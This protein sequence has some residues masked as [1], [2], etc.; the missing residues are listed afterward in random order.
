MLEKR[1]KE[2]REKLELK[3]KDVALILGVSNKTISGYENGYDTIP[4]KNLINYANSFNISLD[5]L[6][7]L[8]EENKI[9]QPIIIDKI[10]IGNNL[11]ELRKLNNKTQD[12]IAS[13]INVAIGAYSN[14]E[15]GKYLISVR[16]LKGL[17]NIYKPFS[18]D[19]LFNRK[20]K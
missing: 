15:N 18:I 12:Y 4:M 16:T 17:I 5:Y 20:T 10:S 11:K 14:Y 2:T 9:Y 1:L 3:E 13:K 7:R 8:T 19:K 6:F